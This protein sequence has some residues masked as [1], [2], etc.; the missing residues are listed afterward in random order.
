[1]GEGRRVDTFKVSF[2]LK[3]SA[4][5]AEAAFVPL[6]RCGP[7]DALRTLTLSLTSGVFKVIE[8][9]GG[10]MGATCRVWDGSWVIP[11]YQVISPAK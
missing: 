10:Q 1:M 2:L 11:L 3:L 8:S 5:E 9:R 4:S 6:K 7:Q